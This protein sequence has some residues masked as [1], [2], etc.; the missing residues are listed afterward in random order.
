VTGTLLGVGVGPGDPELMTLKAVRVLESAPV[1]AYL[2][3]NEGESSARAIAA[4][5]IPAGRMEIAIR[6]PMR[7]GIVPADIY[8]RA[9]GEIAAHLN[10]GRDVAVLCEGDPFFYG[11]YPYLHERLAPRFPTIVVPGVSSLTACAAAAGRPLVRR[12][13]GLAVLPATLPD[14]AL[15]AHLGAFEAAAILKV[16]RHLPRLRALLERAGRLDRAVYIEYASRPDER[17]VP[18]VR[19]MGPAPY[20]S[21]IL[22][23]GAGGA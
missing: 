16:G 4:P 10:A 17:V 6:V 1:L 14:A 22:V 21:M 15:E 3:P 12:D 9:A 7:P 2:A 11:S 19:H 23:P 13:E 20:F 5:F 8:D 18:L